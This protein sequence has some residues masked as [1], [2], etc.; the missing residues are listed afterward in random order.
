MLLNKKL[1][2]LHLEKFYR[3]QPSLRL[4]LMAQPCLPKESINSKGTQ[5]R[6]VNCRRQGLET[7]ADFIQRMGH[8]RVPGQSNEAENWLSTDG[9]FRSCD[10]LPPGGDFLHS[11]FGFRGQGDSK[12]LG[13]G[14]FPSGR[15]SCWVGELP[16]SNIRAK[17]VLAWQRRP[18][19]NPALTYS[20]QSIQTQKN[21]HS[22]RTCFNTNWYNADLL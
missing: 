8:Q 2:F 4:Y 10:T 17:A 15:L 3:I 6:Q 9:S 21:K 11:G 7:Q 14:D 20:L 22:V 16:T 12:F 1:T 19:R 13:G 5:V 18:K